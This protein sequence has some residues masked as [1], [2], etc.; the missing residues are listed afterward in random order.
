[1]T[2]GKSTVLNIFAKHLSDITTT[3]F[4]IFCNATVRKC[5]VPYRIS[6]YC[7]VHSFLSFKAKAVPLHAMNVLGGR[8]G[9]APTHS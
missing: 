7:K 5:F 2:S 9:I 4:P 6:Q 3:Q 8:G 1:V